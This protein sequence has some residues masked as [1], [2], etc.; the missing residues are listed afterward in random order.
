MASTSSSESTLQAV[1]AAALDAVIV[2]DQDGR[3][4]EFNQVAEGMFGYSRTK[5]LGQGVGLSSWFRLG[6][7][8]PTVPGWSARPQAVTT[9]SR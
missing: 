4:V 5:A 8:P 9:H 6:S 2:T 3:V 1:L 7:V